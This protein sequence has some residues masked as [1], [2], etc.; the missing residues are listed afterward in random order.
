MPYGGERW[1]DEELR[2]ASLC[3]KRSAVPYETIWS[4]GELYV[5]SMQLA[6][7]TADVAAISSAAVGAD[8]QCGLEID[9][10]APPGA[11]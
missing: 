3:T 5:S 4:L 2:P 10:M 9:A 6:P 7:P 1:I 11:R 8:R